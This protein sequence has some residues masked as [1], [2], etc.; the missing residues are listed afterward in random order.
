MKT[1]MSQQKIRLAAILICGFMTTFSST[2]SARAPVPAPE[3]TQT[4]ADEWINSPP[5]MLKD[6]RGKVVLI[7]VWTYG[8]VNCTRSIPWLKHLQKK[9]ADKDFEIIG[10]HSPEFPWEKIKFTV[11]SKV[12]SLGVTFPVMLDNDMSYWNALENRY[13]PSFYL[14]NKTG[15]IIG[16]SPGEMHIGESLPNRIEAA[17]DKLLAMETD[18]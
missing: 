1:N 11:E 8:C 17:I 16:G 4:D 3:F 5:L 15:G 2:L 10:I 7:D 14:M 9:Y 13:W 18:G 12:E 6:L